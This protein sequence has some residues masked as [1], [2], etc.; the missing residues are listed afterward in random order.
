[1]HRYY[2][3]TGLQTSRRIIDIHPVGVCLCG[4]HRK[5]ALHLLRDPA[6]APRLVRE[7]PVHRGAPDEHAGRIVHDI[8]ASRPEAPDT[9]HAC[10][11]IQHGPVTDRLV[12]DKS[13]PADQPEEAVREVPRQRVAN[14][15]ATYSSSAILSRSSAAATESL[16]KRC[17][18]W[19]LLVCGASPAERTADRLPHLVQ[20][21][22]EKQRRW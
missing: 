20:L 21:I 14:C 7:N 8:L 19:A 13:N 6:G 17:M 5:R 15:S 16:T 1:M 10:G 12:E 22:E 4:H 2:T 18:A 11:H 9:N 3:E